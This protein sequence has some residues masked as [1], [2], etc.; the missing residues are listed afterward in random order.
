[1]VGMLSLLCVCL[2]VVFLFICTVTDFLAMKKDRG[3]K[4][5][6][7]VGILSGQIFS[8]FGEFW[9]AGSHGGDGITSGCAIRT[10]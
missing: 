9:L 4:F 7:H 10:R 5:C 1:M 6:V 3:M 2:F 8:P